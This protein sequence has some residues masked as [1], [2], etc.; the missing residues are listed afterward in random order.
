MDKRKLVD[1]SAYMTRDSAFSANTVAIVQD[2]PASTS[3]KKG[4]TLP[5]RET[6]SGRERLRSGNRYG[7]VHN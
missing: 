7:S 2:L 1:R 5:G 3:F 6:S 4:S